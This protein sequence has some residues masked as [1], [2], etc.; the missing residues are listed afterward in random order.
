MS[1]EFTER[2]EMVGKVHLAAWPV[3][4]RAGQARVGGRPPPGSIGNLAGS[5]SP[6]D[7][8]RG[9]TARPKFRGPWLPDNP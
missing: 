2:Y 8:L 5:E 6:R 9:T 3:G 1:V 7:A 4:L